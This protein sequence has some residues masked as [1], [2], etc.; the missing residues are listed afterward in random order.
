MVVAM[1]FGDHVV[2]DDVEHGAACEGEGKRQDGG[3]EGYG[4]VADEGADDFDKA[5]EDG[6]EK[7]AAAAGAGE[8]EGEDCDHAF[9]DVLQ[10]D[11]DG[12]GEGVG[13]VAAAETD[14][15]GHAFGEVVEGDSDEEEE[16]AVFVLPGFVCRFGAGV[17][18]LVDRGDEAFHELDEGGTGGQA[19]DAGPDAAFGVCEGGEE[20]AEESCAEHEACGEAEDGVVGLVGHFLDEE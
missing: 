19:C 18:E 9:G 8:Q 3:G 10:G 5:G 6:D 16:D 15:D 17:E 1:G 20:K 2:A 13:G 4:N 7:G 12:D 11:A 14:A